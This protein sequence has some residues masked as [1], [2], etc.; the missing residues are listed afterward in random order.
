MVDV[1]LSSVVDNSVVQVDSLAVDVTFSSLVNVT[2]SSV[3]DSSVVDVTISFVVEVTLSSM[4]DS[5]VAA[6]VAEWVGSLYFSTLN[7]SIISL[8]CLV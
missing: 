7:H 6:P 2:L 3:V 4:V 1:T 8:L 5:S